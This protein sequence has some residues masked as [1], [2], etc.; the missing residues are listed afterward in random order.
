MVNRNP[1]KN[2]RTVKRRSESRAS[3]TTP[4]RNS[5]LAMGEGKSA[6]LNSIVEP[7]MPIFPAKTLKRLRYATFN[8]LSS[9]GGAVDS[10]VFRVN[11]LYDTDVTSTGHQPMGFDQMMVFYE[12]F[13]VCKA[14]IRCT[15]RNGA[16]NSPA[17][18]LRVDADLTPITN[19]DQIREIGGCVFD[20]LNP[21]TMYG[22]IKTIELVV[23]IERFAGLSRQ[24]FLASDKYQGSVGS[25]PTE[26]TYVHVQCWDQGGGNCSMLFD[27][28]IEYECYFTEP[29]PLLPSLRGS[30]E[31]KAEWAVIQ[32]TRQTGFNPV[33]KK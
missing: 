26:G 24:N 5:H 12:H 23:D 8:Q 25:S 22:S 9:S 15:F 14:K 1:T 30:L 7:W 2:K 13:H 32:P 11:D 27:C 18:S 3:L 19:P 28:E 31:R 20:T 16:T 33:P 4:G 21:N 6:S 10:H 17:I 29:R